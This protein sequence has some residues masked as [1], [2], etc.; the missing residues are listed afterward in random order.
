MLE[1]VAGEIEGVIGLESALRLFDVVGG[2][3]I[4]IPKAPHGSKL[5]QIIGEDDCL[6]MIA[7]FGHGRLSVPMGPDKGLKGRRRKGY[8]MLRDGATHTDV[9]RACDVH[10]RS[11]ANWARELRSTDSSPDQLPLDLP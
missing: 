11:V 9:A 6:R 2:L 10:L 8:R 7:Y 1:G 3:D 4:D 5:A